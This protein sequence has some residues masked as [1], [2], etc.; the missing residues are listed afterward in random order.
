[1]TDREEKNKSC[2]KAGTSLLDGFALYRAAIETSADGFLLADAEVRIMEVN[3]SYI[4][5]SGYSREELLS[6]R[7]VDLDAK[8]SPESTADHF[9]KSM[10]E[11]SILFETLHRT[12]DGT[13]WPVELNTSYR[14]ISGGLF[15]SFL[16]DIS[17]RKQA[18]AALQKSE[19]VYCSLF[20][21]MLNGFAYCRMLYDEEGQPADFIYLSVNAAFEQ[22]TGLKDVV[23][24][25]ASSVIPGIHQADAELLD[26]YGR[27]AMSGTSEQFEYYLEALKEWYWIS[28]YSPS[29]GYFITVF[30]V[31]TERKQTEVTYLSRLYLMQFALSHSCDELLVETLDEVERITGSAAGFFH[32]FDQEQQTIQLK[33]WSTTTTS[34]MCRITERPIHYSLEQ[35]GVWADC[36]RT[37]NTV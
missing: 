13:L 31:I 16:R 21:N 19:E 7:V 2:Q 11:G 32:F 37:R 5:R 15:F 17:E 22:K 35:A 3:G 23:G 25:R 18:K 26:I 4:L 27:V 6:L 28:V 30:D 29:K 20:S 9:A 36:I 10:R 14:H 8:E 33:A 1:M 12:K 34:G 24:R